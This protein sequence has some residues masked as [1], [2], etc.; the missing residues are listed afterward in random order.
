MSDPFDVWLEQQ[1]SEGFSRLGRRPVHPFSTGRLPRL[2][3]ALPAAL[4]AKAVAGLAVAALAAGGGVAIARTV[5]PGAFGQSVSSKA[6]SCPKHSPAGNHGDCVSDYTVSS[7][8]GASR[9]SAS[10]HPGS[11]QHGSASHGQAPPGGKGPS[12]HA[13]PPAQTPGPQAHPTPHNTH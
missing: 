6:T 11:G 13:A 10:A 5:D 1:L 4:S 9:R 8:P 2:G 12:G 7:N 3:L